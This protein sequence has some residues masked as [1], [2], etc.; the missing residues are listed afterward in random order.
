[1]KII[2]FP[3]AGG[4]KYSFDFLKKI[5]SERITVLE[6][7]GRGQRIK[8]S[9]K[10]DLKTIIDDALE[11]LLPEIKDED[12]VI[13][14]H[15]MGALV[16]YLVCQRIENL[17]FRKPVKLVVSGKK[18][19][20]VNIEK[21]FAYLPDN[22]FWEEVTKMGGIPNELQAHPELI[23]YFT[24]ILKADFKCIENYQ[25]NKYASKLTIPI[26]V[27]YGSAEDITQK[28]A[29]AW[30]KETTGNVNVTKLQGNHFFIFDHKEI[31][32]E[33]FKNLQL[34]TTI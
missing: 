17:G 8:E 7:S 13:Y 4:N 22:L 12:Y 30:Q 1:M 21:T 29:N 32:L 27:F 15:S 14:G 10:N 23:E 11:K 33:Y 6:Y 18:A 16:G 34:N 24:P 19:P 2:A 9:L 28:E 31:F 25:Y 3:F 20:S 5:L 26:D